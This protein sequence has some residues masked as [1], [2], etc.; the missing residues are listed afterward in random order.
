MKSQERPSI[1]S[2]L[3]KTVRLELKYCERCGALSLHE[4]GKVE[5]TCRGCTQALGWLRGA[6]S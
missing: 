3:P 1:S 5:K 2:T 6:N 4:E